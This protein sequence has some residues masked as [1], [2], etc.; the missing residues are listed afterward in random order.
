MLI[1]VGLRNPVR[2]EIKEKRNELKSRGDQLSEKQSVTSKKNKTQTSGKRTNL[3]EEEKVNL[4]ENASQSV[5]STGLQISPY[6][7]NN[8]LTLP[9]LKYKLPFL[10]DFIN[11]TVEKKI[12]VF[13]ATCSQINFYSSSIKEHLDER[14][15]LLCLHRKLDYR[16][17]KVFNLFNDCQTGGVLFCTDVMSSGIDVPR[18]D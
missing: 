4:D 1:K 15:Q 10:V 13:F 9:S 3:E 14:A 18:V 17:Q 6:L 8:Y 2:I 7:Q 16:R 5:E 12:I 11:R